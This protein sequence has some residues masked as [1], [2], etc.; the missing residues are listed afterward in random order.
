MNRA[1]V[2]KF[3]TI[4]FSFVNIIIFIS[5]ILLHLKYILDTLESIWL[6]VMKGNKSSKLH[7]ETKF[8]CIEMIY[9]LHKLV[10]IYNN[11]RKVH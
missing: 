3:Y 7:I 1:N 2:L 4:F 5:L 11:N 9:T 6:F 10:L 8:I